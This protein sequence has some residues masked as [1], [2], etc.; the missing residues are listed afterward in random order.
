[1]SI[2]TPQ[3]DIIYRMMTAFVSSADVDDALA[4]S[5]DYVRGSLGAEA[6]S[7][8]I[9][10][11]DGKTVTCR[12][13][14]GP[15]DITGLEIPSDKGIVGSVIQKNETRFIADCMNDANFNTRVDRKTGFT[16][17]SM[18]C[19]PVTRGKKQ[20]GAIQLINRVDDSDGMDGDGLFSED[21]ATLVSVLASSSALALANSELTIAMVDAE[22]TKRDLRMAVRVQESLFPQE[23][24]PN[25]YG[26]NIPKKGV[27]GDLFDFVQRDDKVYFCMGDV[28]GKG[29]NAALI[30]SKTHSL[31]RSFTRTLPQTDV[32]TANIN[33]EL[34]ETATNGMFVTAIIGSYDTKTGMAEIC[35][36]GHEPGLILGQDGSVNYIEASIQPLGIIEF[37]LDLI[38]C[39]K[40]DLRKSRFFAYSDGLTEAQSGG[41]M[42]GADKLADMLTHANNLTLSKQVNAVVNLIQTKAEIITD[43]LTL[44]GIGGLGGLMAEEVLKITVNVEVAALRV[45]RSSLEKALTAY[46]S[47]T[48]LNDK[49]QNI[50]LATDE[51]GQNIIRHA[52][53]NSEHGSESGQMTLRVG[54]SDTH[55]C[56]TITDTAPLVDIEQITPRNLKDIRE[57]GLGTHFIQTIADKAVWAH[58]EGK[59]RLTMEWDI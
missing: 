53:G 26:R 54:L 56:I 43:D 46:L 15:V 51:A 6:A 39:E 25:A 8:F 23:P 41:K 1:M 42:I 36:A 17:K 32:L 59:N 22:S 29:I 16:T 48:P 19:A 50:I 37:E 38:A 10:S 28:S 13:C 12:S 2:N 33:R 34:T 52:F 7:F 49:I 20:Y 30:M 58:Y 3:L 11:E 44:L 47:D 57:G 5:L 45:L 24:L 35:N 40:I 14:L 27:S 4:Q 18:I 9:L 31:F 21:D 55:L